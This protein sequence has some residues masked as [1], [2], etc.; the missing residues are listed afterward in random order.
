MQTCTRWAHLRHILIFLKTNL[1]SKAPLN[2]WIKIVCAQ[3]YIWHILLFRGILVPRAYD[4]FGQRWDRRALVSAITGCREI[5]DIRKRMSNSLRYYCACSILV[6]GALGM[7]ILTITEKFEFLSIESCPRSTKS[8]S[9]PSKGLFT[10][11]QNEFHSGMSLVPEWSSYCIHMTKSTDSAILKTTVLST[12]LKTIRMRHSLQTTRFAFS[13]H[14]R[15]Q[16]Y[17]AFFKLR[18]S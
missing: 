15:P 12:I 1:R 3:L 8:C 18:L 7:T 9:G 17:A 4:L 16:S 11:Y 2:W 5:H 6:R 13:S 10:W 14:S